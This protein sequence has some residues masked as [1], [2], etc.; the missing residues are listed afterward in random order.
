MKGFLLYSVWNGPNSVSVLGLLLHPR[1]KGL[2]GQNWVSQIRALVGICVSE[3][4]RPGLFVIVGRLNSKVVHPWIVNSICS[5]C[6]W[7][8]VD[9]LFHFNLLFSVGKSSVHWFLCWLCLWEACGRSRFSWGHIS[10]WEWMKSMP[11]E[12]WSEILVPR[13]FFLLTA[14][15]FWAGGFSSVKAGLSQSD[16]S[17]PSTRWQLQ[18]LPLWIQEN[19]AAALNWVQQCSCTEHPVL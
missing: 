1:G 2:W 7:V 17:Y 10:L 8:W 12:V 3:L 9:E 15:Y 16:S 4:S 13:V 5:L 6:V 19:F 14:L 18:L 11:T